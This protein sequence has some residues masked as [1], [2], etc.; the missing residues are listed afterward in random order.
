MMLKLLKQLK[1]W[2][3]SLY[4]VRGDQFV[5]VEVGAFY[6]ETDVNIF[7]AGAGFG[8]FGVAA[9]VA[10][11]FDDSGDD[12]V[13]TIAVGATVPLGKAVS[14]KVGYTPRLEFVEDRHNVEF[15]EFGTIGAKVRFGLGG[16]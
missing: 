16:N 4:L 15:T 10:V 2:L 14:L 9:G 5:A 7:T 11:V 1:H 3:L 6:N 8:V 12:H 13:K